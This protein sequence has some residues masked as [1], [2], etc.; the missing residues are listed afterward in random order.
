MPQ[1]DYQNRH[2]IRPMH[3]RRRRD[4]RTVLLY[5]W[6]LVR[7]FRWTLLTF[8]AAASIGSAVFSI[9]PVDEH[10]NHAPSFFIALY[11]AWMALLAQPYFEPGPWYVALIDGFY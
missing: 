8:F 5:V 6:A 11:G 10:G 7:E 1:L 4:A 2:A 9:F 3:R